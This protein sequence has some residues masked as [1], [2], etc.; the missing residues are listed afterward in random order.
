[1]KCPVCSEACLVLGADKSGLCIDCQKCGELTIKLGSITGIK[2]IDK[3]S[4]TAKVHRRESKYKFI[5]TP[6]IHP[7]SFCLLYIPVVISIVY[8]SYIHKFSYF[9]ILVP[10]FWCYFTVVLLIDSF[11]KG[12]IEDNQGIAIRQESP[13]LYWLKMLI[14]F[15]L[16]VF[17]STF[18]IL[19][20]I[21]EVMK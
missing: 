7:I 3:T 16:Y 5:I 20:A 15:L 6:L 4:I 9:F 10:G 19:F 21:Q 14:W 18:P 1:M 8:A 12:I 17:A 11:F 13:I 2:I